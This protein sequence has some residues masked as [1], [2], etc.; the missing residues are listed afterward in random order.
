MHIAAV[1]GA[2]VMAAGGTMMLASWAH[3]KEQVFLKK[4]QE[5]Q[6]RKTTN[7]RKNH[8]AGKRQANWAIHG[9]IK[10]NPSGGTPH[11]HEEEPA[12]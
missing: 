3:D 9:R 6:S 2:C 5:D 8:S 12:A 10:K 4:F 11:Y 7:P 1:F